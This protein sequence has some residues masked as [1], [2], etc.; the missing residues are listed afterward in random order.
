MSYDEVKL[1]QRIIGLRGTAFKAR[2][3]GW[4]YRFTKDR[5]A[6]M[7]LQAKGHA[8]GI[9]PTS[10]WKLTPLGIQQLKL[11]IGEFTFR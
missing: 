5:E 10:R 4:S 2:G 6:L 1:A 11:Q 9:G 8:I 7:S 3:N